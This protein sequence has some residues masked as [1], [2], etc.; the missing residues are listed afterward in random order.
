MSSS[1]KIVFPEFRIDESFDAPMV[2]FLVEK[3]DERFAWLVVNP[4]HYMHLDHGLR[5]LLWAS[6]IDQLSKPL[7]PTAT[8]H[9]LS[10]VRAAR[11]EIERAAS[12][13][14]LTTAELLERVAEASRYS[15]EIKARSREILKGRR[16]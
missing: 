8:V 3:G 11:E 15:D 6:V 12:L 5:E 14:S 13:H 4:Q 2:G 1:T 7:P 10:R 9:D 16:T